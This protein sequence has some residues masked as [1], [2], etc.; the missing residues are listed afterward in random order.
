[1][2]N[3]NI[4]HYSPANRLMNTKILVSTG[5]LINFTQKN[6]IRFAVVM[7]LFFLCSLFSAEI[8]NTSY[9]NFYTNNSQSLNLN[10]DLPII[11]SSTD[12]NFKLHPDYRKYRN[13]LYSA[14]LFRVLS[15]KPWLLYGLFNL[16]CLGWGG[17]GYFNSIEGW[18][19]NIGCLSIVPMPFEILR[20]NFSIQKAKYLSNII[21]D[22]SIYRRKYK[23]WIIISQSAATC[24]YAGS[25]ILLY[26]SSVNG[27]A[28]F[29]PAFIGIITA[30]NFNLTGIRLGLS[31]RYMRERKPAGNV[32]LGGSKKGIIAGYKMSF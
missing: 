20:M 18:L 6:I 21:A 31:N 10:N 11:K 1:M 13:N 17:G 30:F 8:S 4:Y 16:A 23:K 19:I 7:L 2:P 3:T 15:L 32:F 22:K 28:G 25:A 9:S 24:L 29:I 12:L 5:N 27:G 14:L 26:R